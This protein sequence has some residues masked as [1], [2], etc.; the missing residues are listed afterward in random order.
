[1]GGVTVGL[2][3][4]LPGP[5]VSRPREFALLALFTSPEDDGYLDVMVG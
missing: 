2:F 5:E 4:R 1:M 3:R